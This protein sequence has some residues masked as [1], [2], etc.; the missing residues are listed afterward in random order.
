M[1][2]IIQK[3]KKNNLNLFQSGESEK[4]TKRSDLRRRSS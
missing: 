3:Y 1:E 2:K 4:E